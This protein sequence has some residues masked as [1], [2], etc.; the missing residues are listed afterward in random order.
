MH[1]TKLGKLA[2]LLTIAVMPDFQNF[3]TKQPFCKTLFFIFPLWK[4]SIP[5][6]DE[7]LRLRGKSAF[8]VY[9]IRRYCAIIIE[10]IVKCT[11]KVDRF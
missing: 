3:I 5:T 2:K 10:K 4:N 1:F 9:L 8:A 7:I 11:P 6:A